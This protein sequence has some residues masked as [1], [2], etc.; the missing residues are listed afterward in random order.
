MVDLATSCLPRL[1]AQQLL[2][3]APRLGRVRAS[4]SQAGFSGGFWRRRPPPGHA[5][6]SRRQARGAGQRSARR[7]TGGVAARRA[8]RALARSRRRPRRAHVRRRGRS[9][10]LRGAP[11]G[12][13]SARP[14][15]APREGVRSPSASSSRPGPAPRERQHACLAGRSRRH[16][17]V[18]ACRWQARRLPD[19]SRDDNVRAS[20]RQGDGDHHRR[21]PTP[22]A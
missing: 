18:L 13:R 7:L 8:V 12:Q 16:A 15:R 19:R 2:V 14:A 1:E 3:G 20:G 4:A 6:G 9:C 11:T 17:A 10:C 22:Q 5:A 21:G